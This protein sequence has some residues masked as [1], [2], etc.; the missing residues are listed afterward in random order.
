VTV[1]FRPKFPDFRKS[2]AFWK[3]LAASQEQMYSSMSMEHW[4]NDSDRGNGRTGR[5][6]C[7]SAT[8]SIKIF[9]GL[10]WDKTRASAVRG[11]RE[12]IKINLN[13]HVVLLSKHNPFCS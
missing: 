1:L 11:R 8:F 12:K 7:H 13:L 6:T 9:H 4:W 3:V 2:I 5:K 10:T